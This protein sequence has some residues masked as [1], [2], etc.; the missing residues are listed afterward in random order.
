[1]ENIM[2]AK[3][4]SIEKYRNAYEQAIQ[5]LNQLERAIDWLDSDPQAEDRWGRLDAVA[6]RFETSFEYI[7]KALRAALIMK[8][9]EIYG[10]CTCRYSG[11]D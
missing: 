9:I 1:M 8:G 4:L 2:S 3:K 5:S 7:W 11:L 10:H 6:K